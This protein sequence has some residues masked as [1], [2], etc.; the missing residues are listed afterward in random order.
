MQQALQ[1]YVQYWPYYFHLLPAGVDPTFSSPISSPVNTP[2][3]SPNV[4]TMIPVPNDATVKLPSFN[5]DFILPCNFDDRTVRIPR[6]QEE[7]LQKHFNQLNLNSNNDEDTIKLTRSEGAAIPF[8][9]NN[10]NTI[11]LTQSDQ[12]TI[13]IPRRDEDTIKL[14]RSDENTI[15]IVRSEANNQ[16]N[17]VNY[18]NY[19]VGAQMPNYPGSP[20]AGN[21]YYNLPQACYGQYYDMN[22][23][24]QTVNYQQY[25]QAMMSPQ[26]ASPTAVAQPISMG[27][28]AQPQFIPATGHMAPQPSTQPLIS[29]PPQNLNLQTPQNVNITS[30]QVSPAPKVSKKKI[31]NTL[32]GNNLNEMCAQQP[33]V[34]KKAPKGGVNPFA[35]NK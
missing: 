21:N 29:V 25:M 35:P 26:P 14:P 33:N 19:M 5:T 24:L 1:S 7:T 22:G 20:T 30:N 31:C 18:A 4:P 23:Q 9:V 13:K 8:S 17:M 6:S 2:P 3:V 27:G 12:D 34:N 32:V 15:K 11:K 28:L 10:E 16:P